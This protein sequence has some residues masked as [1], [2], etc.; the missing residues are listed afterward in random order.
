MANIDKSLIAELRK[1]LL[2][3]PGCLT[4]LSSFTG[5]LQEGMIVTVEPGIYFSHY[6]LSR[7]YLPDPVHSKYINSAVL[8]KYMPVGGV[9]IEDDILVT[10]KGYENL[11]TAPKGD[12]AL[13]IIRGEKDDKFL[14]HA[15]PDGTIP[16][17]DIKNPR[18]DFKDAE[19]KCLT[20]IGFLERS[21]SQEI[22]SWVPRSTAPF[23]PE[24]TDSTSTSLTSTTASRTE[25]D[26][27]H[28]AFTTQNK[29]MKI[30]ETTLSPL[31][32]S[33]LPRNDRKSIPGIFE[34]SAASKKP[35]FKEL[36]MHQ[37]VYEKAPQLP[38]KPLAYRHSMP[39]LPRQVCDPAGQTVQADLVSTCNVCSP[40]RARSGPHSSTGEPSSLTAL[41]ERLQAKRHVRPM[42][43]RNLPPP[44]GVNYW[45]QPTSQIHR[46]LPE[47]RARY[48]DLTSESFA[49]ELVLDRYGLERWI[50]SL[51]SL[52]WEIRLVLAIEQCNGKANDGEDY[53]GPEWQASLMAVDVQDCI[54]QS[55][56]RYARFME[57]PSAWRVSE[58]LVQKMEP[59]WKRRIADIMAVPSQGGTSLSKRLFTSQLRT[60]R[61][62]KAEIYHTKA[63]EPRNGKRELDYD[64]QLMLVELERKVSI[65]DALVQSIE[66]AS[67][68]PE[69]ASPPPYPTRSEHLSSSSKQERYRAEPKAGHMNTSSWAPSFSSNSDTT[70]TANS[71]FTN[72][73]SFAAAMLIELNIHSPNKNKVTADEI[74]EIVMKGT[75]WAGLCRVLISMGITLPYKSTE[76][77]GRDMDDEEG[78]RF[79]SPWICHGRRFIQVGNQPIFWLG[80]RAI[81]TECRICPVCLDVLF[82]AEEKKGTNTS[83]SIKKDALDRQDCITTIPSPY[84][85]PLQHMKSAQRLRVF[86]NMPNQPSKL[87]TS[88]RYNYPLNGASYG[89]QGPIALQRPSPA[90]SIARTKNYSQFSPLG[91]KTQ[92]YDPPDSKL[93]DI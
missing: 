91:N 81:E 80:D 70:F 6:A 28:H 13:K 77:D 29:G 30:T 15:V 39:L 20:E 18:S 56:T 44:T 64:I 35:H 83:I 73:V 85:P 31:L 47:W 76:A 10:S 11:T 78:D 3:S 43:H 49:R 25:H 88:E 84:V 50:R 26:S 1:T 48:A 89:T 41:N 74:L 5:G 45:M 67:S 23:S 27:T 14:T 90:F 87:D 61:S 79:M 57:I 86:R 59:V 72:C 68:S 82:R 38:V 33:L 63:N 51:T 2:P 60:M 65:T 7:V 16:R 34:T 9:R 22:S 17:M 55:Y 21:L 71:R 42:G 58:P 75:C 62:I 36:N 46:M 92:N 24:S 12:E 93:I 66:S 69:T 32:G 37:P 8:A 54:S 53:Q 4:A 40:Q 52:D 19:A